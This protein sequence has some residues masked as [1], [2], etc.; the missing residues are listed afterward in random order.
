[1]D[2]PSNTPIVKHLVLLGG[3]HSHLAVL[4][5]LAMHRV[6]G[7]AITLISRDIHTPY[8][9]ML[10][11][12]IDGVYSDDEMHIDLRP[13]A[14]YAGARLIRE[15]IT[16]LDL[17][18]KRVICKH[19]PA[20]DFDFISLNIGSKPDAMMIPGASQHA[21]G[22]KPIDEFLQR[23][24]EAIENAKQS[25]VKNK[26]FTL[27][28]VGGGPA[29][30]ELALSAHNRLHQQLAISKG[31]DS[32]IKIKIISGDA[33][34]LKSHNLRVR[35]QVQ[36]ELSHAN[37]IVHL[38]HQ[39][40]EFQAQTIIC[41][42]GENIQAD[43]IVLATGAS[44]PAW[45]SQCGLQCGEDGFIAVNQ[46]LQSTSHAFVFAAGDAASIVAQPRPKSGVFAVRQGLPLAQ[47]LIRFATGKKLKAFKPQKHALA[48]IY[49]GNRRAIASRKNLF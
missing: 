24:D 40:S 3:G 45:P 38:S 48:L 44:L 37:I 9:G 8:S 10:P 30:V 49:L 2:N 4:K 33:V 31:Q 29:T 21:I 36:Q 11:A 5:H 25:L 6:A 28:I 26:P 15:E 17:I 22:I 39:V 42:N 23:L 43:L 7:L 12:Y 19:R 20:I 14:Q 34:L 47:N 1:M 32:P 41:D 18:N 46:Y 27:A 35:E 16:E 13:L